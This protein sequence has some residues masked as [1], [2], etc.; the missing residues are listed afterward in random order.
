MAELTGAFAWK[1]PVLSDEAI[2]SDG[3]QAPTG[4]QTTAE[5]VSPV[6]WPPQSPADLGMQRPGAMIGSAEKATDAEKGQKKLESRAKAAGT[7]AD[8][9]TAASK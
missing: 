9:K 2:D 1:S 5:R 7:P 3:E 8:E 6:V 4:R